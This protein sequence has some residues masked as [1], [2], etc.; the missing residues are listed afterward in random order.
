MD[1]AVKPSAAPKRKARDPVL[2]SRVVALAHLLIRVLNIFPD[3]AARWLGR[4]IG[5]LVWRLDKRHRN[6]VLRHM[7]IAF[8]NDKTR[9]EKEALCL[10]FF[11][12]MCLSAVEFARLEKLNRENIE[13][14]CDLSELKH[15]DALLARGNGLL[16]IASHHGN[17]EMCGYAVALKGYPIQSVA[18]PL[19]NPVLNELI[20]D[21]RERA[22]NTIIQKWK[23]LW[24]LKKL[25][26]RGAIVT[27]SIDQNGGVSGLFVPCFRTLAS[28]VTSPAELHLAT[29]APMLVASM[30][31][32]VDGIHHAL[33]VWDIIEHPKSDDHAA[34]VKTVITRINAAVEKAVR[35]Y[36]EQW[37]W[38]HK[39]WKTR[40]PGEI[41]GPDGLPPECA[42]PDPVPQASSLPVIRQAAAH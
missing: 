13:Q 15:F 33:C 17:W 34:D 41:E 21:I 24:K 4:A 37:L 35:A 11:E 5:R 1:P 16:C 14:V 20:T 25:L 39:R 12:H 6:A 30:V 32:Q 22:G 29:G 42:P 9:A 3:R 2:D 26:D 38:V 18:R 8:R 36:P 23:V 40:P 28:T 27:M 7:D 19:D 10:K 31:R